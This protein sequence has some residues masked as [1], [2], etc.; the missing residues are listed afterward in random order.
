M[1]NLKKYREAAGLSQ[2]QLAEKSGVNFRMI[3]YYE[4]R[5]KDINKA[6]GLRLHQLAQALGCTMEN[7]LEL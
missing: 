2:S 6:E 5:A 1:T 7:L 3:Q 4:Q